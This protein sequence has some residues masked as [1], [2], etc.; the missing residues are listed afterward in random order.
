MTGVG[1]SWFTW[2]T[3]LSGQRILRGK[4]C[5]VIGNTTQMIIDRITDVTEQ[6]PRPHNCIIYCGSNDAVA[7][8]TP[9]QYAANVRW[10]IAALREAG[11]LPILSTIV[12]SINS[13]EYVL[14][15]TYNTI[16][17]T[18]AV[19]EGLQ[20]LDLHDLMIDPSTGAQRSDFVLPDGDGV[21]PS[22]PGYKLVGAYVASVMAPIMP[23]AP[24]DIVTD[25][26]DPNNL[27]L[28]GLFQGTPASGRAPSWAQHDA[29]PAG[30]AFSVVD[31]PELAVG[32]MQRV[33]AVATAGWVG[34][35]QNIP[36]TKFSP[37]DLLKYSFRFASESDGATM[38]YVTVNYTGGTP[39]YAE[40]L[41]TRV[42]G[43]GTLQVEERVPP[44]TTQVQVVIRV[45]AGT[46]AVEV[47]QMT[48]RNMTA[49][50]LDET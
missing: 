22:R 43:Q 8:V 19:N 2:A 27:V 47:G 34:A 13:P 6:R 41:R 9:A 7:G 18:I 36:N 38:V 3:I 16:L 31:K 17:R 24:L 26:T 46:G 5:G 39:A 11:I 42:A 35:F 45:A 32:K 1:D 20:L 23:L 44:G 21:H 40:I 33:A 49:L 15:N 12:P 4:N 30:G 10:I 14:C 48:I 37:G 28:N 25:P 50:G 29:L